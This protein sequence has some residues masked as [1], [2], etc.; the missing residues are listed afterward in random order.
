MRGWPVLSS[1]FSLGLAPHVGHRTASIFFRLRSFFGMK[2]FCNGSAG[3][4]GQ[5][6]TV[7][8]DQFIARSDK[9]T[10]ASTSWSL[11]TCAFLTLTHFSGRLASSDAPKSG[12]IENRKLFNFEQF[13]QSA[14]RYRGCVV[15][16]PPEKGWHLPEG[17]IPFGV[18]SPAELLKMA[19]ASSGRQVPLPKFLKICIRK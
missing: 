5:F 9:A 6:G 18:S 11:N 4:A 17:V 8:R 19:M 3:N 14:Q 13:C 12:N 7:A 16:S 2:T 10:Q 1:H 15:R